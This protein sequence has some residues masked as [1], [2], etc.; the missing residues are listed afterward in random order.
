MQRNQNLEDLNQFHDDIGFIDGSFKND[1]VIPREYYENLVYI[2]STNQNNSLRN[3]IQGLNPTSQGIERYLNTDLGIAEIHFLRKRFDNYCGIY[4]S[5]FMDQKNHYI[6]N[7]QEIGGHLLNNI[8]NVVNRRQSVFVDPKWQL[9]PI[10]LSFMT[11]QLE[12]RVQNVVTFLQNYDVRDPFVFFVNL[13]N[14]LP[15]ENEEFNF[16]KNHNAY[17]KSSEDLIKSIPNFFILIS[18]GLEDKY[19]KSK[20]KIK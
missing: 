9:N 16:T 1:E 7:S 4:Y 8:V 11:Q 10:S 5:N 15:Y 12:D 13:A 17:K 2:E 6:M 14:L 18:N 20:L 19:K 3:D